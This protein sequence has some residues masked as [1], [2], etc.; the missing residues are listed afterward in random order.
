MNKEILLRELEEIVNE[1]DVKLEKEPF[2]PQTNGGFIG[3][4]KN[5]INESLHDVVEPKNKWN[6]YQW[7]LLVK[8]F[9]VRVF[10]N[11]SVYEKEIDKIVSKKERE[12]TKENIGTF[13]LI[14]NSKISHVLDVLNVVKEVINKGWVKN[15]KTEIIRKYSIELIE[16]DSDNFKICPAIMGAILENH[17][18]KLCE[19]NDCVP[20]GN[21]SLSIYNQILYS[22]DVYDKRTQKFIVAYS[23]LRNSSAH[24]D[25]ERI[26]ENEVHQFKN[27]LIDFLKL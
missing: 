19:E 21:G 2:V 13:G 27:W 12:N 16:I 15:I 1:K 26:T 10:G 24:G 9:I 14:E 18:R 23:D 25:F 4:C 6:K 22:R 8:N 20:E 3:R 17:L 11:D 7:F 5:T